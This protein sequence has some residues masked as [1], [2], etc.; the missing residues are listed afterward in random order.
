MYSFTKKF[1]ED[2]FGEGKDKIIVDLKNGKKSLKCEI[3]KNPFEFIELKELF[4]LLK[5]FEVGD[6]EIGFTVKLN[7]SFGSKTLQFTAPFKEEKREKSFMDPTYI[8]PKTFNIYPYSKT[9]AFEGKKYK[10]ILDLSKHGIFAEYILCDVSF[11]KDLKNIKL[12]GVY[13]NHNCSRI[14]PGSI[15]EFTGFP[16]K[17]MNIE[18]CIYG[19]I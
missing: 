17:S 16:I 18:V 14:I 4:E 7:T 8:D 10:K 13:V 9:Y 2:V 19:Y 15:I 1:V 6:K 11:N 5:D 12:N 3:H